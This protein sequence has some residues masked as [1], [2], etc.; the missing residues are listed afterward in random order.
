MEGVDM[1]EPHPAAIVLASFPL[2]PLIADVVKTI[3]PLAAKNSNKVTLHCDTEIATIH[4]DQMRLRQALLNLMS[5]ANK[6]T[7]Q[8]GPRSAGSR[9]P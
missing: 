1:T 4:A 9:P 6:F 5:N 8:S 3:E 2:A 7:E